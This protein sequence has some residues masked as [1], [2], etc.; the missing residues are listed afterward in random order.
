[1]RLL[2]YFVERA[3]YRQ[4][5]ATSNQSLDR[6][7]LAHRNWLDGVLAAKLPARRTLY[8]Q[9]KWS[10]KK[11]SRKYLDLL[12]NRLTWVESLP[13]GDALLDG[14]RRPSSSTWPTGIGAR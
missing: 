5:V 4:F 8:N 13:D 12:L 10:A 14:V 1:M 7:D 3:E 2:G 9:I 11:A 6:S